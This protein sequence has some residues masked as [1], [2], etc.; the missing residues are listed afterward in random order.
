MG[1]RIGYLDAA[2]GIAMLII[3]WGHVS[4]HAD[5]ISVWGSSFK[6]SIFFIIS[7][8][9]VC[10]SRKA[11][12]EKKAV[13]KKLFKSL[14]VP[15]LIFSLIWIIIHVSKN[16][17]LYGTLAAEDNIDNIYAVLTLRG[18]STLWFLPSMFIGRLIFEF[19]GSY[20]LKV[21]KQCAVCIVL[22]AIL[23]IL[24]IAFGMFKKTM[25]IWITYP[26]LTFVKGITAYVFFLSGWIIGKS[27]QKIGSG[28]LTKFLCIFGFILNI[29]LSMFNRRVD[30]NYFSFGVHPL[31]FFVCGLLGSVGLIV[32]LQALYSVS[33]IR[34]T[35]MIGRNSLFFM[36]THPFMLKAAQIA[37][38]MFIHETKLTG[39]YYLRCFIAVVIII[40]AEMVIL[41][42]R[43]RIISFVKNKKNRSVNSGEKIK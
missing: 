15:Y 38:G 9:L 42:F 19:S 41:Y 30:M 35:E 14:M 22:T 39:M 21:W 13:F 4:D 36:L 26:F 27:E 37:S 18:I 10:R 12:P 6:L 25:S 2:K 11:V 5:M 20:R 1:K 31:L 3:I 23:I 17:I 28:K 16:L 29:I 33:R 8:F 43:N 7:G 32:L 34:L 40:I 24:S